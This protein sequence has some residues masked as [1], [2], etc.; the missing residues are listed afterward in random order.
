ML[1]KMTSTGCRVVKYPPTLQI[2]L[3]TLPQ[4]LQ[5]TVVNA[6]LVAAM[7]EI[8]KRERA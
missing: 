4:P 3:E 1:S 6:F 8:E 7:E 2:F 5:E